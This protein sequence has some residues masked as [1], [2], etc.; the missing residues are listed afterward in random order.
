MYP[1]RAYAT[2][3]YYFTQNVLPSASYY[4]IKDA[5]TN[6]III[7]YD[8]YATK[9]SC[10][11]NGSFFNLRLNTFMPE[12]FYKIELK[13]QCTANDIQIHDNGFYFKVVR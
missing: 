4:S 2:S 8:D 10:D 5:V 7:P 11:S 9:I 6:E 1:N 3:S 13:I 12:R